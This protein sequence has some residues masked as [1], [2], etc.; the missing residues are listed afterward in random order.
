M[1]TNLIVILA[2]FAVQIVGLAYIARQVRYVADIQRALL[3]RT[4]RIEKAVNE[5]KQA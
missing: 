2:G 4:D 5:R 3:L 1:D